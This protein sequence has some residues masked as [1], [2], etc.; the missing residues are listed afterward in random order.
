MAPQDDEDEF[1][2]QVRPSPVLAHSDESV[3]VGIKL[4]LSPSRF[5]LTHS[6]RT[7]QAATTKLDLPPADRDSLLS[8]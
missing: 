8:M 2:S 4:T 7:S 3:N 1:D 5:L 6:I